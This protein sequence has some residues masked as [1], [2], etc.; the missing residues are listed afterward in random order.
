[1]GL[2]AIAIELNPI[3][4]SALSLSIERLPHF[5]PDF[6]EDYIRIAKKVEKQIEGSEKPTL[7]RT[8]T[9]NYMS[10]KKPLDFNIYGQG[11]KL[12]RALFNVY[13]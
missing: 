7:E 10:E 3:A 1:M 9:S 5:G 8:N 4:S 6:I 12:S 11:Q 13:I 2:D